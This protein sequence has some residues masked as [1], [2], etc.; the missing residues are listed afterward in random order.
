MKRE[1]GLIKLAVPLLLSTYVNINF[2]RNFRQHCNSDE[3]IVIAIVIA[4]I[5]INGLIIM[6]F[7][8]EG[9]III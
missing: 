8:P 9:G 6:V 7:R 5:I 3:L 1:F 2:S 4:I